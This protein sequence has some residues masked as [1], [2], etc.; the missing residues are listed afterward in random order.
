MTSRQCEHRD[1]NKVN[2]QEKWINWLYARKEKKR[3]EK[4]IGV[5]K[6]I[7][8]QTKGRDM[9]NKLRIGW[10]YEKRKSMGPYISKHN[11]AHIQFFLFRFF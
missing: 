6:I 9:K 3:N 4:R 8:S 5:K 7:G 11:H 1:N 10:E 2:K